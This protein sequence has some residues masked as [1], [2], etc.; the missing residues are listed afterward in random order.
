MNIR[1][2]MKKSLVTYMIM[3]IIL[4]VQVTINIIF[5]ILNNIGN[6]GNKF[7]MYGNDFTT[8]ILF[9]LIIVFISLAVSQG[10]VLMSTIF[11]FDHSLGKSNKKNII[12]IFKFVLF[13]SFLMSFL[14]NILILIFQHLSP[15]R[16]PITLGLDWYR[17]ID[18]PNK[19]II[20]FVI[21]L[22]FYSLA[23]WITS[24]FKRFGVFAGLSRVAVA[25]TYGIKHISYL[26]SYFDWGHHAL[27]NTFIFILVIILTLSHTYVNMLNYERRT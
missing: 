26:L 3:L 21:I 15:I 11:S 9:V 16:L 27:S 25:V 14:L 2:Y 23:I 24:G 12:D 8:S 17:M 19:F 18:L 20:I 1:N 13:K 10:V 7:S 5:L 22:T 4:L 6:G